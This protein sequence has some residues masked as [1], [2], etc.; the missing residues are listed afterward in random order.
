MITVLTATYNRAHTLERL[1]ASLAGQGDTRFQWVVVDDG[2]TDDTPALLQRLCGQAPFSMQVVRQDNSGKH[3]AI[4]TGCAVATGQWILIVDS[5]D[6]LTPDAIQTVHEHIQTV[7]QNDVVGLCFRKAYFSGELIGKSL[8][9][10]VPLAMHPT[11]AGKLF[12]GD[13]AYVF[14]RS[15]LLAHPFPVI[16][17]EKFVPELYVWN[18][19]GDDGRILYFAGKFIYLCEYLD[20][21]YTAN[22]AQHLKR[23]PRGFLLFYWAQFKRERALHDKA[24]F[25][26]RSVQCLGY[27][28]LKRVQP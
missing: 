10:D 15:S 16:P 13:L 14:L 20:D 2:S 5:D 27:A 1:F 6:A 25:L 8:P 17:D 24:K 23:N 21:G 11:D 9:E 28:L 7:A 3:V 26:I 19:I 22:F 18:Q 12:C 4:N